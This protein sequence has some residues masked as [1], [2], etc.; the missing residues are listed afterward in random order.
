M[1]TT[2]APIVRC[3]YLRLNDQQCTAEALDPDGD[4]LV[5]SKHSTRVI[6]SLLRRTIEQGMDP[7][8][9]VRAMCKRITDG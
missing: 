3:R 2:P 5:C 4:I 1:T 8:A 6:G 9:L 7:V